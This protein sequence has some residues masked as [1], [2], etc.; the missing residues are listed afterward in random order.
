MNLAMWGW[1]EN[2]RLWRRVAGAGPTCQ[3]EVLQSQPWNVGAGRVGSPRVPDQ[4]WGLAPRCPA[5]QSDG[6][7]PPTLTPLQILTVFFKA[8]YL[9]PRLT[10]KATPWVL[11]RTPRG[12][13]AP[14]GR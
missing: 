14:H 9:H 7:G 11:V 3:T 8:K 1:E 12:A 5:L 13:Q 4:G 10:P 2:G 6:I